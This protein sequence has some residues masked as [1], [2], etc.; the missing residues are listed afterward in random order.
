MFAG[1][2]VYNKRVKLAHLPTKKTLSVVSSS[3]RQNAEI[4]GNIRVKYWTQFCLR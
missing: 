2:H 4:D 1:R 3:N